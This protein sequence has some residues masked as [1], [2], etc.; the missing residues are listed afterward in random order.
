MA[1]PQ[2]ESISIV[3]NDI[4]VL[5]PSLEGNWNVTMTGVCGTLNTYLL[6]NDTIT[7]QTYTDNK[8]ENM[9]P[10]KD[11]DGN[12]ISKEGFKWEIAGAKLNAE[13][14][15]DKLLNVCSSVSL[16]SVEFLGCTN[17]LGEVFTKEQDFQYPFW[18]LVTYDGNKNLF[19]F[20]NKILDC[21]PRVR[22]LLGIRKFPKV[23]GDYS[24]VA[25]STSGSPYLI[26]RCFGLPTRTMY[27]WQNKPVNLPEITEEDDT[28]RKE[29]ETQQAVQKETQEIMQ[30]TPKDINYV[31]VNS[32]VFGLGGSFQ[33]AGGSFG[34]VNSNN[35]H[36]IKFDIVGLYDEEIPILSEVLW[37]FG[38]EFQ[39]MQKKFKKY[40][41]ANASSATD[42]AQASAEGAGETVGS[43]SEGA[44]GANSE[45]A[46]GAIQTG[47]NAAT[48]P[49]DITWAQL[50]AV[51]KNIADSNV[52]G[53]MK[54]QDKPTLIDVQN[55]LRKF[56][57]L[58]KSK[59]DIAKI[60]KIPLPDE[61]ED[62]DE[63]SKAQIKVR[64]FTHPMVEIEEEENNEEGAP[65]D[66]S[67]ANEG[68]PV[69]ESL[70]NE[71][72]PSSEEVP[73]EMVPPEDKPTEPPE[74]DGNDDLNPLEHL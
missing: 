29:L 69:D 31:S 13:T 50:N 20:R 54:T 49:L 17:A 15:T 21:T 22:Y 51:L 68:A 70:A 6:Y 3:S 28:K 36:H 35:I 62:L 59:P 19:R 66:E 14:K 7:Y 32:N 67:H 73:K 39:D 16:D 9:F 24:D 47:G 43:A 55:I 60:S 33:L 48:Q 38:L 12:V 72:A 5:D 30:K 53:M 10:T 18:K 25:P 71:G 58:E 41:S 8:I 65:V 44:G 45:Q 23:R 2:V 63:D 74:E 1:A 64:I 27:T 40:E 46:E 34:A 11:A 52:L 37:S 56:I 57:E 26:V 4:C 61:L 42:G